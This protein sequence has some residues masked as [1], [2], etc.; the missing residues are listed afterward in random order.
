MGFGGEVQN[1]VW[2]H[3]VE[4]RPHGVAV[5]DVACDEAVAWIAGD[6][7]ERGEIGGVGELVEIDDR[8]IRGA[9]KC[10]QTA[11]PMNPAPPVT[12]TL[13]PVPRAGALVTLAPA[14][15]CNSLNPVNRALGG[16]NLW[17]AKDRP[18]LGRL[19]T[20]PRLVCT[21]P[22]IMR[23]SRIEASRV[24]QAVPWMS[25]LHPLSGVLILKPKRIPGQ[26]RLFLRDL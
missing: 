7:G 15:M 1:R 10:R 16:K 26:S 19:C 25:S 23:R 11:E 6:A 20:C 2:A 8:P 21:R 13:M 9:D 5:G 3:L 12:I 4:K 18:Q 17:L 24:R 22:E 14:S